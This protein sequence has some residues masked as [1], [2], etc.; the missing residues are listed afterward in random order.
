MIDAARYGIKHKT[1]TDTAAQ[2]QSLPLGLSRRF[3]AASRTGRPGLLPPASPE[4][5]RAAPQVVLILAESV[6]QNRVLPH[7]VITMRRSANLP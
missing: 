3:A 7:T 2:P 1:E 4:E 5:A 6:A